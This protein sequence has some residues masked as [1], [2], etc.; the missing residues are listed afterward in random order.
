MGEATCRALL[1]LLLGREMVLYD[2]S[3]FVES[4]CLFA[5]RSSCL[6]ITLPGEGPPDGDTDPSS[7]KST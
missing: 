2:C 4:F 6:I 5:R 3:F 7:R 1:G